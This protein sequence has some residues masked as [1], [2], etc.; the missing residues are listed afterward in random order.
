MYIRSTEFIDCNVRTDQHGIMPNNLKTI[1]SQKVNFKLYL[2]NLEENFSVKDTENEI[3]TTELPLGTR[4]PTRVSSK[5]PFLGLNMESSVSPSIPSQFS[6]LWMCIRSLTSC[7][8][9]LPPISPPLP[10][11]GP[12]TS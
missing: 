8:S 11:L 7:S 2:F 3:N 5:S 12:N 10:L 9:D 4:A 1:L 6:A